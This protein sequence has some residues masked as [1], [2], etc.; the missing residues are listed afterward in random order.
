VAFLDDVSSFDLSLQVFWFRRFVDGFPLNTTPLRIA[1]FFGVTDLLRISL[2]TQLVNHLDAEDSGGGT[3]LH[4][5]AMNGRSDAIDLLLDS[6]ANI[7]VIGKKNLNPMADVNGLGG[8]G[9]F[10][11]ERCS[12]PE[13]S[14][15]RSTSFADRRNY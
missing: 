5:A 15:V 13:I 7:N 14:R 1:S 9:G 10:C 11:A 6:G 2:E 4:W 12:I 8:E 3:A